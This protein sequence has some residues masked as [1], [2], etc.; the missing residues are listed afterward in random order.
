MDSLFYTLYEVSLWSY[1]GN[2]VS[3]MFG[4]RLIELGKI[5]LK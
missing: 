5:V 2:C 1:N 3:T 4:I